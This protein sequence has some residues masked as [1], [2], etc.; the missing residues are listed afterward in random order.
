VPISR[1]DTVYVR[2]SWDAARLLCALAAEDANDPDVALYNAGRRLLPEQIQQDVRQR[3]RF[4]RTK[5][6]AFARPTVTL[7]RGYGV[8][9]DSARAVCALASVNGYRSR[10]HFFSSYDASEARIRLAHVAAE[11]LDPRWGPQGR[12]MFAEV[13]IAAAYGEHPKLA[14]ERLGI[15]TARNLGDGPICEV[16]GDTEP[17]PPVQPSDRPTST[18][19][20]PE[21]PAEVIQA[22]GISLD[23]RLGP[24][25]AH[26]LVRLAQP[27]GIDPK[28]AAKLLLSESDLLPHARNGAAVGIFQAEPDPHTQHYSLFAPLDV[29]AFL[30]LPAVG[31]LPYAFKFWGRMIRAFGQGQTTWGARDL[32]WLNFLPAR[33]V[34]GAPDSHVL[35][36]SPEGFYT[37]N[38]DALD[39]GTKGF[40]TAGDL[41]L[42]QDAGVH[43][44]RELW[45]ELEPAIDAEMGGGGIASLAGAVVVGGLV[46]GVGY[47]LA[48]VWPGFRAFFRG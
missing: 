37:A 39:H 28:G 35:T 25:F 43:R 12:W 33:F 45:A 22:V 41:S 17:A 15:M 46:L 8:C 40:I 29:A 32:Y 30:A 44:N 3:V 20:E 19:D 18:G 47:A 24:G 38:A 27:L 21:T 16:G 6:Q 31:Q 5:W 9:V 11:I 36:R 26:E 7:E 23:T 4:V 34:R 48:E 13:T 10:L 1:I 2:D 14:A 42:A